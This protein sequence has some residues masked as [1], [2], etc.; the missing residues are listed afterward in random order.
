MGLQQQGERKLLRIDTVLSSSSVEELQGT[1]AR[2]GMQAVTP[3][4]LANSPAATPGDVGAKALPNTRFGFLATLDQW[5]QAV[6]VL[7][8]W[9][10]DGRIGHWKITISPW[11]SVACPS[12]GVA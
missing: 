9:T 2:I 10:R 1:L 11:P 5:C 8:G 3:A 7:Q 12:S 6:E 4:T